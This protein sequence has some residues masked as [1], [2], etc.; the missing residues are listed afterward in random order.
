MMTKQEV[1]DELKRLEQELGVDELT[2][3]LGELSGIIGEGLTRT[4]SLVCDLRDFAAPG[5][6]G[7]RTSVSV[8]KGLV[9]TAQLLKHVLR[10]ADAQLELDMG[11]VEPALAGPKRPQDRIALSDMKSQWDE[12]LATTFGRSA[13]SFPA[14]AGAGDGGGTAV[15]TA[16][17]SVR[18]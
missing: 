4:H 6:R 14:G 16:P 9:S 17:A 2:D 12:D 11:T 8:A 1:R 10:E 13:P 3:T 5:A 7:E 18:V 15:A